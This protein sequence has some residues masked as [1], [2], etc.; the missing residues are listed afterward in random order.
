MYSYFPSLS[1]KKVTN[2]IHHVL[3]SFFHRVYFG[4][5]SIYFSRMPHIPVCMCHYV[6]S[7]RLTAPVLFAIFYFY[8][9]CY[10][11]QPYAN[12]I[13]WAGPSI[14]FISRKGIAGSKDTYIYIQ[15]VLSNCPPQD[16]CSSFPVTLVFLGSLV[17]FSVYGESQVFLRSVTLKHHSLSHLS[18]PHCSVYISAWS[19]LQL[20]VLVHWP[21]SPHDF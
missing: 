17:I 6:T 13:M 10:S 16:V 9:C 4:D 7:R 12:I 11:K 2:C 1:H 8:K 14:G 5:C 20:W 3:L 19:L 15:Q 18:F 21:L